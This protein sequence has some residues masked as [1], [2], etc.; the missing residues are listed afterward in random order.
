[1]VAS[2]IY[3]GTQ[4]DAQPYL[5]QFTALNPAVSEIA[6]ITWPELQEGSSAGCTPGVFENVYTIGLGQTD[7]PTFESVFSD[8]AVFSAAHPTYNGVLAFQRY[9][10]VVSSSMPENE[11]V[12]PWRNIKTQ[13]YPDLPW[14][15]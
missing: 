1:M 3:Y 14:Y 9:S 2:V 10:N 5:D 15:L 7:V 12:Y 4:A 6:N 8:L 13:G 11:T